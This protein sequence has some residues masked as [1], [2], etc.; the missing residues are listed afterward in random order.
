ME[1]VVLDVYRRAGFLYR[2]ANYVA[3]APQR[4]AVCGGINLYSGVMPENRFLMSG[5]GFYQMRANPEEADMTPE[6][7]FDLPQK[8]LQ[9]ALAELIRETKWHDEAERPAHMEFLR[10][11]PPFQRGYWQNRPDRA[12]EYSLLRYGE[13]VKTYML[14]R[15]DAE[16]QVYQTGA[17]PR[18]R[19]QDFLADDKRQCEAGSGGYRRFAAALL[20]RKGTLPK[21]RVIMREELAEICIDYRLPLEEELFF[22]LYSWP[23][24]DFDEKAQART[25]I[26]T[27]N[28]HRL[29]AAPVYRQVF[30]P[31][32]EHIGYEFREG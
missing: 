26:R 3:A 16:R 6:E 8:T 10:L 2:R 17:I 32:L 24:S 28:F 7:L 9:E 15:W 19:L 27:E 30:R 13:G 23:A 21:I 4:R 29:M 18:W 12:G 11:E 20:Q 5:L 31:L 22:R 1:N 25:K 14:Y